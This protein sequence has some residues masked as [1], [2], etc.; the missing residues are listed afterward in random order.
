[1]TMAIYRW[2]SDENGNVLIVYQIK[3]YNKRWE[4]NIMHEA[5]K[6]HFSFE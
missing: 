6:T 3:E 1:M 4:K 2:E 5:L